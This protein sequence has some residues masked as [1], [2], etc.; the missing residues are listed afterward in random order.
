MADTVRRRL[1]GRMAA[2]LA[3]GGLLLVAGCGSKPGWHN[4]G[5][6]PASGPATATGPTITSPANGATDVPTS[7]EIVL[8]G[9]NPS[10]KVDLAEA[11][12]AAVDGAMRPDGSSWVAANQLKYAT[13]YTAKVGGTT[14][15]FT[16]MSRPANLVRVSSAIG[17]DQVVGVAA[18]LVV[19]FGSDVPAGQRA[20]VEKRLFVK[21]EPAQEGIWNWFNGHEVH[22]RPHEYW[23]PDTKLDV[24]LAT[25]GL[26]LG[27]NQYGTAD[28]T[29]RATVGAKQEINVDNATKQL[30][31]TKDG[32]VLRTMPVSLGKPSTPSYSGNM[33]IMVKN[34][35]EWFDS[36]TFGIPADSPGGYRTKVSWTMRLTW[37]GQY[38][39]A[40]PW[41]V[42]D[43]GRRNVSH[44]CT[45]VSTENAD[46][47]WHTVHIGDP[48]VVKGTEQNLPWG[49]GWTD[50]NVDWSEYIKGSAIR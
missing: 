37:S 35:W 12:G 11:G 16:T 33:V 27:G 34:E 25:G 49:D 5:G 3:L 9:A 45:N 6:T 1:L 8:A 41:S 43:Q 2:G 26:P 31:F 30:T 36:G 29:V 13:K 46:W 7:V 21:S 17:D 38:I 44:G 42:A 4:P 39:H 18:P 23:Q 22:Y 32:Q 47:L 48:V 15:S 20:A 40:A 10:T 28:V 19:T 14:V 24:R 50:W